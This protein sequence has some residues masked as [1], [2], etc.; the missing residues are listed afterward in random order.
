MS[1]ELIG[2]TDGADDVSISAGDVVEDIS[3]TGSVVEDAIV[4]FRRTM[5]SFWDIS[6]FVVIVWL[7]TA[8]VF[9][10]LESLLQMIQKSKNGYRAKS[11]L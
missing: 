10:V 1:V 4:E 3:K 6:K 11:K 5:V 9:V 8:V 2:I 7:E